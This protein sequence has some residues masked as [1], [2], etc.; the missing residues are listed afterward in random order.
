MIAKVDS[1]APFDRDTGIWLRCALHAHTTE[2]DGW[3]S[4]VML[5]R[6]HALAGYDVLAI[7]DH[8]RYT[9]EPEGDDSLLVIGATEISLVAPKSNGPLHLLA[10]G[11]SEI[12]EVHRDS[13]LEEA[14]AA[15]GAK[16]GLSNVAHPVWSGLLTDEVGGIERADGI[17]IYNSSCAIEQDRAHADA[18]WDLWLSQGHRLNGIATDDLHYPGYE[19]FRSWTMVR[20]ADRS[21]DA[22]I[23][24]LRAGDF[25]ST[26]GPRFSSISIDDDQLTIHCSPVKSVTVLANPPFGARVTAGHHEISFHARRFPTADGHALEGIISGDNLTGAIFPRGSYPLRYIRVVLEDDQGRRAWSNPMYL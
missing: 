23:A 24:A 7:T 25:Y 18:H 10:I 14:I 22:V 12:P 6:Y 1:V 9:P 26:M 17:E 21:R 2:S 8:D 16:G 5:R 13:T 15:V 4:P 19:A 20:A 3:L 11:I